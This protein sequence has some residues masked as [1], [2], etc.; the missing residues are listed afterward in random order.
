VTRPA[1]RSTRRLHPDQS[2][3]PDQRRAHL[4]GRGPLSKLP[5]SSVASMQGA[6]SPSTWSAATARGPPPPQLRQAASA[7]FTD[8]EIADVGLP[9]P[10]PSR[11]AQDPRDQVPFAASAKASSTTTREASSR[12]CLTLRPASSSVLDRGPAR[13]G[14][15]S[16]L[17]VAVTAG[18]RSTTSSSRCSCTGSFGAWPKPPSRRPLLRTLATL[19]ACT[20]STRRSPT[21]SLSASSSSRVALGRCPDCCGSGRGRRPRPL[22]LPGTVRRAPS[23]GLSRRPGPRMVRRHGSPPLPST[24]RSTATAARTLVEPGAHVP[25]VLTGLDDGPGDDDAWWRL[26]IDDRRAREAR[27]GRLRPVGYWGLS[28]GTSWACPS[29]RPSRASR[30]PSSASWA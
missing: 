11:G 5:L 17:A 14:A 10:T 2:P 25:R 1:W 4:R 18:S 16:V 21:A 3:L 30:R 13:G 7:I 26:A 22:L 23:G 9:R 20:G 6:R 28:M 24:G 8:P 12:S 15:D 27:R 19:R 29:W